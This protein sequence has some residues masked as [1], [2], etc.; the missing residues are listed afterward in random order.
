MQT[1]RLP[2]AACEYCLFRVSQLRFSASRVGGGGRPGLINCCVIGNDSDE[3]RKQVTPPCSAQWISFRPGCKVPQH[4]MHAAERERERGCVF[5]PLDLNRTHT[6]TS[7]FDLRREISY[8]HLRGF[9]TRARLMPS[10]LC[11]FY[12]LFGG[13]SQPRKMFWLKVWCFFSKFKIQTLYV[14]V[15]LIYIG[16]IHKCSGEKPRPIFHLRFILTIYI[17]CILLFLYTFFHITAN[18]TF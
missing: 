6:T 1:R 9:H 17:L 7:K 18:L 14:F 3:R 2:S 11:A 12:L 4:R 10:R 13:Y 5:N 16:Q 15:I 8:P